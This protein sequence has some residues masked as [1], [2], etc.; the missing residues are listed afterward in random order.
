M[1][2]HAIVAAL[3]IAMSGTVAAA[4]STDGGKWTFAGELYGWG[5]SIDAKTVTGDDVELSLSDIIDDLQLVVFAAFGARKDKWTFA[6]DLIFLN[7]EQT[8]KNTVKIP[9]GP[10][11]AESVKNDVDL[12]AWVV[13]PVASYRVIDTDKG[14]LKL[15][16]GL[17][18][19]NLDVKV[20]LKFDG[21]LKDRKKTLEDKGHVWDGIVGLKGEFDLSDK[22]YVPYYADIGTGD[23]KVTWQGFGGFGYR[24]E[25]VE[26]VF[27][28]RYLKWRFDDNKA[29]DNLVVKGPM[30]GVKFRF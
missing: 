16:G 12:K 1:S 11:L 27:G 20:K 19:L 7:I 13:T 28:Y 14:H 23:S 24:F 5:P 10:G 25:K 17:R 4:E 29:L 2:S 9:I 30:A 22:W 6:S 3:L 26:A 8:S 18:Y 15:V 21:P